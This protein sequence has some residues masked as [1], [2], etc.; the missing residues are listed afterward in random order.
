[1]ADEIKVE[2]EETADSDV[3]VRE[4]EVPEEEVIGNIQ[5]AVDVVSTIAGIAADEIE[6]VASMYSSFAGGIA[7]RLGA[8]KNASKGVK[9]EMNDNSVVIDLYMV[10]D[11]G[12]KIPA[13]AWEV[14]E[15]VKNCVETMTGLEVDKVNIHIEGISFEKENERIA[16]EEA[17]AAAAVK[18]ADSA[19]EEEEVELEEAPEEGSEAL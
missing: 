12:V 18:E 17:E 19:A 3:E 7:E 11:Y 2:M 8:K 10:V 4:A 14:Q 5:I 15:N 1:M 16:L 6:G 9:V 13:L